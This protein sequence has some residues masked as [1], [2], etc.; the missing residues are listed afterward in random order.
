MLDRR[1]HH[2]V[3]DQSHRRLQRQRHLAVRRRD[4]A[5]TEIHPHHPGQ[6]V[7]N[8]VLCQVIVRA[9][10]AHQR[11]GVRADL[12]AGHPRRQGRPVHLAAARAT[13]RIAPV[14]V[15]LR[16]DRRHI[17]HL[18]ADRLIGYRLHRS[19]TVAALGRLAVDDPVHL[20]LIQQLALTAL[21]AHLR[22]ALARTGTALGTVG[23]GWA[24][25]SG[26]LGRVLGIQ[27]QPLLQNR[28]LLV[29]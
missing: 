10:R 24:V 5:H 28:Q 26:R 16:L 20:R 1:L 3:C 11:Q 25:R 21:V 23:T 18:V 12:P 4:G 7:T 15:H 27:L 9:Q 2:Q 19:P 8:L 14:F 17:E 6:Q 22:S 13:P 29:S